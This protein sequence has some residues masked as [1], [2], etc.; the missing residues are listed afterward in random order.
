M[1]DEIADMPGE[2]FDVEDWKQ[3][4]EENEEPGWDLSGFDEAN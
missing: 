2:I 3:V 4:Q 1:W